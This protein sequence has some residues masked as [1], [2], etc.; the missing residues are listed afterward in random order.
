LAY[1]PDNSQAALVFQIREG[2]YITESP[3]CFLTDLH[4]LRRGEDHP[5]LGQPSSQMKA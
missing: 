4:P 1:R 2:A 5:D 3:I